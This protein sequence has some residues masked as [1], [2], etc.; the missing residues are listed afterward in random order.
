MTERDCLRLLDANTP[1]LL[2]RG[3]AHFHLIQ[4][5]TLSDQ[6]RERLFHAYPCSDALLHDLG[7]QAQKIKAEDLHG[8]CLTVH[9]YRHTLELTTDSERRSFL[10]PDLPSLEDLERFFT[11]H[12]VTQ[13]DPTNREKMDP[14]TGKKLQRGLIILSAFCAVMATFGFP[15]KILWSW[16]CLL[17]SIA[18]LVLP[19][20]FP[21]GFSIFRRTRRVR[22]GGDRIYSS[23][24]SLLL[25]GA[26]LACRALLELHFRLTSY[27]I[28]FG[29]A[30]VCTLIYVPSY[31]HIKKERRAS[32]D[33]IGVSLTVILV[34]FGTVAQLDHLL[35][36]VPS[37][38]Y[39]AQV[40]DKISHDHGDHWEYFCTVGMPDGTFHEIPL[41]F[42]DHHSIEV[43]DQVT[44]TYYDGAF[45]LPYYTLTQESV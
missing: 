27:A 5:D 29:I 11:G 36:P 33:L 40:T 31:L 30:L 18:A 32:S 17:C 35:Y 39:T 44:V 21:A 9:E 38:A 2:L 19:L 7:L 26:V 4:T 34:F 8:I 23:S 37:V 43:G 1:Y 28:L 10:L 25:P 15:P 12:P 6:Q 45:G 42:L 41:S 13:R 14:E 22:I 3:P 24:A 16:L 20:A